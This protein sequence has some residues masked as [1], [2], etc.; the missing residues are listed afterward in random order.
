[1]TTASMG[2]RRWRSSGTLRSGPWFAVSGCI[3]TLMGASSARQSQR[4]TTE[5]LDSSDSC[6][7]TAYRDFLHHD[8]RNNYQNYQYSQSASELDSQPNPVVH[9]P[10][11]RVRLLLVALLGQARTESGLAH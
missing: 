9:S 3:G 7:A 6:V 10:P 8:S 1:M 4:K 11:L 5:S 2:R